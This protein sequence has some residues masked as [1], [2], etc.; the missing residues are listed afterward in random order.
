MARLD[1]A[2]E[3]WE[4]CLNAALSSK[5]AA[6]DCACKE[7]GC[8]TASKSLSPESECSLSPTIAGGVAPSAASV[9]SLAGPSCSS[10]FCAAE[11]DVRHAASAHRAGKC[12]C[13]QGSKPEQGKILRQLDV[14]LIAM[15]ACV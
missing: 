10:F 7:G 1:A 14:H 12:C 4:A 15:C 13:G 5:S 2:R 9:A 8:E 11:V 3:A 6:G